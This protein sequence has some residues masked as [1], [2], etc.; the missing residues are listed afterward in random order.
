MIQRINICNCVRR[1]YMSIKNNQEQ[2]ST[3]LSATVSFKAIIYP[4]LFQKL[5]D[6]A[7]SAVMAGISSGIICGNKRVSTF[8]N[9]VFE[10]NVFPL[11]LAAP[12]KKL[13][14]FELLRKHKEFTRKSNGDLVTK[15]RTDHT[16]I[17]EKRIFE[18]FKQLIMAKLG[19]KNISDKELL[20]NYLVGY[21]D[22][23]IFSGEYKNLR[24]T[25][26]A[27]AKNYL[28]KCEQTV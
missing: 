2:K 14:V 7:D 5:L 18:K 27:Y 26:V 1:Q 17:E 11:E 16:G 24:E 13:Y 19:V 10:Y 8:T 12:D 6:E 9:E 28:H 22:G 23:E 20:E 4:P 15:I 3:S 25:I 21:A